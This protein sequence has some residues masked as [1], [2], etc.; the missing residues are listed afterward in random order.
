MACLSLDQWAMTSS[1]TTSSSSQSSERQ[2]SY[3]NQTEEASDSDGP[4]TG[5]DVVLDH[6]DHQLLTVDFFV[7]D[8]HRGISS[9]RLN[10]EADD[11]AKH[12]SKNSKANVAAGGRLLETTLASVLVKLAAEQENIYVASLAGNAL[13]E[14]LGAARDELDVL[15]DELEAAQL[16]WEQ[17]LREKQRLRDKNTALETELQCHKQQ[18]QQQEQQ[19]RASHTPCENF[20][21]TTSCQSCASPAVNVTQLEQSIADLKRQSFEFQLASERDKERQRELAEEITR[22]QDQHND[23]RLESVRVHQD[24][25]RATQQLEQNLQEV[26]SLQAERDSLHRT[27]R[28]LQVQNEDL[29]ARLA[30]RNECV[31]QLEIDTV[32]AVAQLQVAQHRAVNAEAATELVAKTLWQHRNQLKHTRPRHQGGRDRKEIDVN[33]AR[34]MGQLPQDDVAARRMGNR[35]LYRQQACLR[36]LP[37]IDRARP[38][39]KGSSGAHSSKA[40]V[41]SINSQHQPFTITTGPSAAK[42]MEVLSCNKQE[43]RKMSLSGINRMATSVDDTAAALSRHVNKHWNSNVRMA[44]NGVK[45]FIKPSVNGDCKR[46][47]ARRLPVEDVDKKVTKLLPMSSLHRGISFVACAT[48]VTAVGLLLRQYNR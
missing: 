48:V 15:H 19:R 3:E 17:A 20:S 47:R 11:G 28:R 21:R 44:G 43:R 14:E 6:V 2:L 1:S 13:L 9:F 35:G 36:E 7:G 26:T 16:E 5:T 24:L 45:E 22:L 37:Q 33:K 30:A 18:T 8:N 34:D 12:C 10:Q 40:T 46:R 39:S 32:R 4:E 42:P 38:S 29:K 31:E 25:A 23:H 27:S 41:S